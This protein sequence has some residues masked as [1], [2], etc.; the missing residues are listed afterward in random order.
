MVVA[1]SPGPQIKWTGR[2]TLSTG[3]GFFIRHHLLRHFLG[4]SYYYF[5]TPVWKLLATVMVMAP[6]S[7]PI[8]QF[9]PYDAR[10]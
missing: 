9:F 3:G 1:S 4:S 6:F 10:C 2:L 5:R 8:V 7:P